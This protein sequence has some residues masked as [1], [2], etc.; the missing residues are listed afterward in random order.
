MISETDNDNQTRKY[1]NLPPITFTLLTVVMKVPLCNK[2]N[3]KLINYCVGYI[4]N[5]P[6]LASSPWT[7]FISHPYLKASKVCV[8]TKFLDVKKRKTGI[9]RRYNKPQ[10]SEIEFRTDKRV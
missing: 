9:R 2:I 6:S 7:D 3:K 5:P 4:V 1:S 10:Y 8:S